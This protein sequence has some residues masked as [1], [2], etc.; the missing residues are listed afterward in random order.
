MKNEIILTTISTEEN[1]VYYIT[2]AA[3]FPTIP[4]TAN[5]DNLVSGDRLLRVWS[6]QTMTYKENG[7]VDNVKKEGELI[8]QAQKQDVPVVINDVRGGKFEVICK[9]TIDPRVGDNFTIVSKVL[10]FTILG[11]QPSKELI[12]TALVHPYL[13]AVVYLKSQ[14]VQFLTDG[15]PSFVNGFGLYRIEQPTA[16]QIW[17]WKE[18]ASHAITDFEQRKKTASEYPVQLRA[19]NPELYKNLPDFTAKQIDTEALQSYGTGMY[20][21]PKQAP[22]TRKWSWVRNPKDDGYAD[23]C[24]AILAEVAQGKFPEGWN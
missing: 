17:N 23:K 13:S 16:T 3:V 19:S 10:T 15:K 24:I 8:K 21:I 4:I 11:T 9:A 6:E 18:N 12:R 5:I 20:Y 22:I 14:F 2:D 1:K 7:R